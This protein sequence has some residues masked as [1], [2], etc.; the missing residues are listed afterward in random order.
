MKNLFI[1]VV[2][3]L[4]L[5]FSSC[6]SIFTSS[7][8]AV[9]IDSEPQGAKLTIVNKKGEEVYSGKTPATVK[10]DNSSKYMSGES[11]TL[12]F[13][14]SGYEDQ[15][16][17]IKSKIE[18]WYWGNILFGGLIGMLVVDPLTGAM[19]KLDRESVFVNLEEEGKSD[20][21][22]HIID[23]NTLSKEQRENLIKL[24]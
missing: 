18:G 21:A 1:T 23:I 22:L 9:S 5:L 8:S 3:L 24:N 19:Y 14:K 4:S 2:L 11:Y 15:K 13:S 17:Y 12:T 10:L 16:I 6:A 7:T 20:M